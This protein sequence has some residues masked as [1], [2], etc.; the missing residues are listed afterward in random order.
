MLLL[1][2]DVKGPV[3][4]IAPDAAG[5]HAAKRCWQVAQIG[6]VDPDH[7]RLDL[8]AEPQ[9]ARHIRGPE[10][11]SQP[12]GRVVGDGQCLFFR[13]ETYGCEYGAEHFGLGD[14]H[15]CARAC[16]QR[17]C[18]VVS[19]ASN[20]RPAHCDRGTIAPGGVNM[21][22]DLCP[23]C[24]IDQ[25]SNLGGG[26]KGVAHGDRLR[27]LRQFLLELICDAV[28]HQQARRGRATLAIERIGHEHS[29]IQSGVKI[30]VVKHDDRVLAA[31]FKVQP[32][33]GF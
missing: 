12:V 8:V 24:V 26:I 16:N 5:F 29:R 11:G 31:Q 1:H 17:W 15:L 6:R 28:L 4:A 14:L 10:K 30:C 27:P 9:R 23:M 32:F 22:H 25:R 2:I 13:S 20:P 18:D 33:Q 7:A 21:R 3:A 19:C